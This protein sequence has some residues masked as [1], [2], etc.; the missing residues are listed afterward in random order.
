MKT[1]VEPKQDSPKGSKAGVKSFTKQAVQR[2][3]DEK[4]AKWGAPA[5]YYTVEDRAG[6]INRVVQ[7]WRVRVRLYGGSIHHIEDILFNKRDRKSDGVIQYGMT[8]AHFL[9]NG[10]KPIKLFKLDHRYPTSSLEAAV[11][12]D[13]EGKA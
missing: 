10:G 7:V 12:W 6:V 9:N 2:A 11:H 8:Y 13:P 1:P 5:G 3:M 4:A